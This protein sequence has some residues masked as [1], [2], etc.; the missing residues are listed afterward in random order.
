MNFEHRDKA[1]ERYRQAMK[2][3]PSSRLGAIADS[4]KVDVMAEPFHYAQSSGDGCLDIELL[5]SLNM[6]GCLHQCIA[7]SLQ[8]YTGKQFDAVAA[9]IYS[10][11]QAGVPLR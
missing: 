5:T 7:Q 10:H 2:L 3:R 11:I 9:E 8:E 4:L 6:R 1:I